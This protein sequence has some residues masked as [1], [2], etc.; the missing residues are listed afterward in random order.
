MKHILK[1]CAVVGA[2]TVFAGVADSFAASK[3]SA[4]TGGTKVRAR[5]EATG[6]YDEECYNT[7]YACMDNFCIVDNENGGSCSCSDESKKYES[8]LEEIR[9]TL[10]EAER[11]STEEVEKVQAGANADIIFGGGERVYNADGSV[12]KLKN[13]PQEKE[14]TTVKWSSIYDDDEDAFDDEEL[15]DLTG[16]ALY[17][18][19]NK[20]CQKQVPDSCSKDM[21]LLTQMYLRQITSDCKGLANSITQKKQEANAALKSAQAAVRGALKDSLAQSNKYD[22]G[23]CMVEFKKCMMGDDACGSDWGQC[24][25]TIA[26]E[27]MQNN[28]AV[29]TAGTKVETIKKYDITAS[30]MERLDSKRFICEKVLDQCVS[31][32]DYV[33]DDFLRESA[34]TIRLAEQNIESQKRQSCMGDISTCIQK[35]CKEDIAGKGVATMDACLAKP[36]MARSFCKVQID[37]CERMEPAI[38]DYVVARLGAMRVDACTT[39][40]KE[41]LTDICGA[42]YSKCIGLDTETIGN[43]CPEEKLVACMTDYDKDSV[44]DYVAQIAQG[45]ALQIDNDL[46]TACQKALDEATVKVCG[47]TDDCNNFAL[48]ELAGSRS[49]KYQVCKY[50]SISGNEITWT[51]DCRES[52]DGISSK[53]VDQPEG[54]GWAGKL[55]GV[56]YWGDIEYT[57]KNPKTGEYGFTTVDEYMQKL[58]QAGHK[59]AKEDKD[60]IADLVYGVEIRALE[61]SVETTIHAI[62]SDPNVIYCM[63]GRQVEGFDGKKFGKIGKENARFPNLT[64]S[65]RERIATKALK[66]AR[67]NYNKK[68]DEEM[69]RMMQDQIKMAG[70]QNKNAAEQ[71]CYDWAERSTLPNTATPKANEVGKWIA[72]GV[73]AA[74]SVVAAVFTAGTGAAVGAGIIGSIVGT[75]TAIGTVVAGAAVVAGTVATASIAASGGVIGNSEVNN[76][77]YKMKVSTTFDRSTGECTKETTTQNC[78]KTKKNYCKE[79]EEAQTTT[80]KVK[81]L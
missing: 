4:I 13:K 1:F 70:E 44:R 21:K 35:A 3:S 19:A 57:L 9:K 56:V 34:P 40:V 54:K 6:V 62:E 31:V 59:L 50:D 79:W 47:D 22:R 51:S 15:S 11:I 72:V 80:T 18:S 5:V 63:T 26:A 45:V 43:M 66:K 73:I 65:L 20:L 61:N 46:F 81:L 28:R 36:D 32:R 24:V 55:S 64:N 49:F 41:C 69:T 76:W 78:K 75:E 37:P 33:W 60:I 68:Y 52:A 2:L 12:Q 27:N 42:D 25:F 48:D 17:D 58:Q 74:A 71:L 29:S 67:E 8:D 10:A 23:T 7:Y 16:R 77:N 53:D 14:K 38:W 39:E 30:T